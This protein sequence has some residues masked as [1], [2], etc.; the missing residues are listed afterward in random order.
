MCYMGCCFQVSTASC[1][2][3]ERRVIHQH[4]LSRGNHLNPT[5][6]VQ[7][8]RQLRLTDNLDLSRSGRSSGRLGL[9][10]SLSLNRHIR[11]GLEVG[12]IIDYS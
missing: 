11:G 8:V 5:Y 2:C 3:T 6:L 12:D 10:R 7:A 1:S 9:G 4:T